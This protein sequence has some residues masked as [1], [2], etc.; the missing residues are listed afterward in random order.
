MSASLAQA[1]IG[2]YGF[3]NVTSYTNN[4][5]INMNFLPDKIINYRGEMRTNLQMLIDYAKS[6][7][8]NFQIITHEGQQ[9]LHKSGWEQAQEKY[10]QLKQQSGSVNDTS[11]L[12]FDENKYT[13]PSYGSPEQKYLNSV[14]AVVL[15]NIYCGKGKEL[16][17]TINHNLGH[18]S[19]E[20]CS[21]K[22]D[23]DAA[24]TRSILDQK[25]S[26]IFTDINKSFQNTYTQPIIND[27]ARNIEHALQAKNIS[28]ILNDNH[29]LYAEQMV[30]EISNSNYDIV[31]INPL[32]HNIAPFSAEDIA[33]MK[34]KKNGAKRLLIA[35]INVSEASEQDIFW[36]PYW[37]E[38]PPNWLAHPSFTTPNAYIAEYWSKEWRQILSKHFK[39][40]IMS[41]YDGA[42][43]TGIEN[44]KFFEQQTPLE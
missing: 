44:H 23:V 34:Y 36:D 14:N 29:Y 21:S 9:I 7:I 4:Q 22:A 37:K 38:N 24:I 26:Y 32:F 42:F 12:D 33:R 8:P 19:I 5:N 28:F 30:H 3:N 10:N 20:Q 16:N 15:N 40:I 11:F 39:N 41:K 1:D 27:S 2:L 43:F 18:F 13:E 35:N 31:V 17:I 25:A 6:H